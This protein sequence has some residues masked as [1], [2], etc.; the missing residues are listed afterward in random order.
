[1]AKGINFVKNTNP[2]GYG[3]SLHLN[4]IEKITIEN[5]NF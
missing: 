3:S 2:T 4:V 5:C 1:M